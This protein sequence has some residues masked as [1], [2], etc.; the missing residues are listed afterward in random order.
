M[1]ALND[2]ISYEGGFLGVGAASAA[3]DG[4]TAPAVWTS[5]DGVQWTEHSFTTSPP[6]VLWE[7]L[8][9]TQVVAHGN[10]LVTVAV[11]PGIFVA[12]GPAGPWSHVD[13]GEGACPTSLSVSGSSVVAVGAIG[14]C[15]MG[16]ATRPA[17]WVSADGETWELAELTS[18]GTGGGWISG[19]IGV[20]AG[21]LGWGL[22][23]E[24]PICD[25]GCEVDPGTDPFAG[26]PWISASGMTWERI[27][28]PEP[29]RDASIEQVAR[30]GDVYLALGWRGEGDG[31][32]RAMWSSSDGLTWGMLTDEPPFLADPPNQRIAGGQAGLVAWSLDPTASRL[33][34]SFDGA[35]WETGA[36][37]NGTV[38]VI[39][40]IDGT[41]FALGTREEA[42]PG[43][44]LPCSKDQVVAGRCRTVGVTWM[45][46]PS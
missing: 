32:V 8:A 40:E 26:A 37:L 5:A 21:L 36:T 30:T 42:D 27:D 41:F 22:F 24:E 34:Y 28:D 9:P 25:V 2:L 11:G 15:G 38:T 20:E 39:R 29:F 14:A 44:T 23:L 7:G 13:L 10:R 12:D 17:A 1:P 4:M 6:D 31:T 46:E 35:A 45:G 3:V 43:I 18:S 19:T 33:W 16:G